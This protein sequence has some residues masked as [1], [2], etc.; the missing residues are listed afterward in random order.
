M[1]KTVEKMHNAHAKDKMSKCNASNDKFLKT[2][3]IDKNIFNIHQVGL[4]FL[5]SFFSYRNSQDEL[6]SM[7][8]IK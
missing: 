3:N 2:Q 1:P 4:L 7:I 5:L 8:N 6:L